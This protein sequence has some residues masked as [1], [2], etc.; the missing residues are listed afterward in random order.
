MPPVETMKMPQ[1]WCTSRCLPLAVFMPESRLPECKQTAR[2]DWEYQFQVR[3]SNGS[4]ARLYRNR[5]IDVHTHAHTHAHT[6][7]ITRPLPLMREVKTDYRHMHTKWAGNGY[8]I[9]F[10]FLLYWEFCFFT[11]THSAPNVWA[12]P[13]KIS[14]QLYSSLST[15]CVNSRLIDVRPRL[16]ID[17]APKCSSG[18]E[19]KISLIIVNY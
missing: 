11:F 3:R 19:A 4:V 9:F 17:L 5:H 18:D 14:D 1:R 12:W 15:L 2:Q 10:Y 16:C 6:E 7:P 8:F 13:C